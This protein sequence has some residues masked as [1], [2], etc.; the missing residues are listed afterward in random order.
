MHR[1]TLFV[2][3]VAALWF[4]ACGGKGADSGGANRADVDA[5]P[6]ALLPASAV[7]VANLDA[8]AMFEGGS[9]GAQVAALANGLV[10][11]GDDAGF[12]AK[13]DVDRVVLGG[14]ATTGADVAAVVVGRFDPPRIA[15]V[16]RARSGAAIVPGVYAGTT[17]Y[18]VGA[19]TYAVLTAKT[20]VSGT[21]DGVRRLLERIRT[22]KL[23]RSMPPWVVQTL[24]TGGAEMALAADFT[25]QPVVSA[26]VG[27][28]NL[29]WLKG[30]RIA[31]V[32]GDFQKP[33]MNVAATLTY[34][35]AQEAAGA[36]ESLRF[37]DGWLKVLGPFLG[38][39]QLQN[40]DV[41]TEGSDMSCKFAVDGQTLGNLVAFVLHFLPAAQ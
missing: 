38:G 15:A 4:G 6:L 19:V 37:V 30:M 35:D 12:D 13:R 29:P 28:A 14:Y 8:R 11:V 40:L 9:V 23:E 5:D 10:P 36:A 7:V 3:I 26:A 33:G 34:G 22:G 16:T 2:T 32:V 24:A 27:S 1:W 25:S 39:L 18:S 21:R 20:I 31:R 41:K 17:T